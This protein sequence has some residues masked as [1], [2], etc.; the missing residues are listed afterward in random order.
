RGAATA[1]GWPPPPPG[2]AAHRPAPA[3]R[4]CAATHPLPHRTECT[5]ALQRACSTPAAAAPARHAAVPLSFQ[6]GRQLHTLPLLS[7]QLTIAVTVETSQ[8][9]GVIGLPLADQF[10]LPA[11]LVIGLTAAALSLQPPD[12]I[13]WLPRMQAFFRVT[14]AL[15]ETQQSPETTRRLTQW[16]AQAAF[17]HLA[18]N[19]AHLS[20]QRVDQA[21]ATAIVEQQPGVAGSALD[22][23]P[24][25]V[26]ACPP[27]LLDTITPP[28]A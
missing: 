26:L 2:T 12:G 15:A 11:L 5:A 14:I 24:A 9:V 8:Q 18:G 13:Q 3:S 22:N 21:L 20:P 1:S 7:I 25:T 4:T 28:Q 16:M 27:V 10:R 17:P 19:R 6:A 23:L